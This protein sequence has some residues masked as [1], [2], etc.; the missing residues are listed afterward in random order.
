MKK[1]LIILILISSYL[2][3]KPTYNI[4]LVSDG[5][6]EYS[7]QFEEAL[8]TEIKQILGRDFNVKFPKKLYY[9][10]NWNYGKIAN[11]VNKALK[12]RKSNMVITLGALSSHYVA[13]KNYF[14]KPVIAT[15]IINPKMQN[16]PYKNETSAKHNLTYVSAHQALENDINTM[17]EIKHI[18]KITVLIDAVLIKNTPS[19]GRYINK[20]FKKR[21]ITV[22]IVSIGK[23]IQ[24]S[25]KKID[26]N[27]DFVYVTPLFQQTVAQKI[28]IYS[29]LAAKELASYASIGQDDV[30]LG[31]LFANAPATDN[32]R[33]IR[34]IALD[35]QQIALG[36][37]ASEQLVNFIPTPALSINM[38]TATAI[39]YLPNW[40]ILSKA[41]IIK[42]EESDSH[43]FNIEEIMDRAVGH[44]LGVIASEH[45]V[46]LSEANLAKADSLFLPQV[47]L[48]AEAV[49]IDE[50]R[51]IASL[52]LENEVKADIYVKFSQQLFNHKVTANISVN[53]NF[54]K[55]QKYATDYVKLDIGLAAAVNYLRI[56]QL[57]TKLK[58]EKSN[59]ELSK[60]NMR[61]AMTRRDIGIGNSSDIYRWQTQISDEKKSLLFTH[62]TLQQSKHSLNALLDLPQDLVLNFDPVDMNNKVFMTFHKSMK[63]YFIDQT[64]FSKF[65]SYLVDTAKKNI[66]S[67]HQYD[68][69]EKA[70]ALI[71]KSNDDAFYLP[72]IAFEGGIKQHFID[73]SNEFR[74][75]DTKG[76]FDDMPYANNLDWQVGLFV[77]FPLYRGGEKSATL[78]ASRASLL[79]AEAQK[80]NLLNQVEKKV[81]NSLYQAK[82]SYISIKLA[83]NASISSKKNLQLIKAVYNQGSIGIIDLLDAQNVALRASLIEN[84][85]R[86]AF[87]KDLLVLQHDIGQVNFNLNNQDWNA[88]IETLE[89]HTLN[90]DDEDEE[91]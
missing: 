73:P 85:T 39:G 31:A 75:T 45:Q 38:Q 49:K 69:I 35:V 2:F 82:A 13:R 65:Q 58:I 41:T 62:T 16:V 53:E 52:G 20:V 60:T 19:I 29:T 55:A 89:N 9:D 80:K 47:D 91:E 1:V 79:I 63:D 3:A 32:K 34:Q 78:E 10:G 67:L 72:S 66:P 7:A 4:A 17:E 59:L 43:F 23:D 5:K 81:R 15:A 40:E 12:N 8:K 36:S 61:S 76:R 64:K 24:K 44:N 18:K 21:G 28:D 42:S 70:K 88:W 51:A 27:T 48:G 50:D 30:E 74:D 25:L 71:V 46:E 77:R 84:N 22:Q 33:F 37:R 57:R 11:K 26:D 6:S 56:L 14:A 83:Q 54:L 90:K 87:M 86:Y 68:A